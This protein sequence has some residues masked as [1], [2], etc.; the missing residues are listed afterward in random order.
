MIFS[1]GLILI[2]GF[3]IGWLL[4]KIKIPGLVGM[5]IVGLLIGPYCLGLIDEKI[6]SISTE[7]RQVALVIILT[8]SGLNLDIDS[9]KKIG[10][11]AILM[12]FIP[13]TLEIIGT[14][15]ISQLLLEITI[16]ESILLGTIL[17]AVSPAVV[18]PRMI[19]LIEER[20]GEKHQVPKLILAGS[21]VDDI[22]VI[23]LFYTFLGLV[24]NNAFDFVSITM[25]PVTIILGVLLGI[26]VGLILSYILKK[27]NF[28]TAINILI[29]ISSSFLMIGLENM[30]KDYISISSLLGIMVIGIILL[31]RNKEQAKQL[32]DGYNNLWIFFEIILFVLVGATVDFSYAINNGLIAILILMIGLLFRTLGVLLCLIKT[33][34]TFKE[35]LFTILAYIP[36]ATVQASI[37]GIALSLGL[38]CGSI[39]LTVSVISILITAPIG[40]ILID[41]LS[42]KLLDRTDL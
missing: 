36:K 11:P 35:R 25:I 2:L 10:R 29:I 5:I 1:I 8:R 37:G 28:K 3:I 21:S 31:F 42:S 34:L 16:F 13:A 38:S 26:I 24:G 33:K 41:N 4:S 15:L 14:T 27:T 19:K 6:L 39:I 30:L 7:L 12:S 20:F 23:V 9:L 22:Y 32:S 17:A 18:S 40:A